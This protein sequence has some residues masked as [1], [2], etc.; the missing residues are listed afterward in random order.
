MSDARK[1]EIQP[2]GT[3]N[4]RSVKFLTDRTLAAICRAGLDDG[5]AG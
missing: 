2:M 1:P 4:P 5:I 3:P